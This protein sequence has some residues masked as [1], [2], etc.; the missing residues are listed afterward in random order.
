MNILPFKNFFSCLFINSE[1]LLYFISLKNLDVLVLYLF[2]S[3]K[4]GLNN[5]LYKESIK[6]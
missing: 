3:S 1:I 6:Y 4:E 5:T 2:Q